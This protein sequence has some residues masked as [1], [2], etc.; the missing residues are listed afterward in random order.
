[1]ET[2]DPTNKDESEKKDMES[3]SNDPSNVEESPQFL[4]D[5]KLEESPYAETE[6]VKEEL[7]T[8]ELAEA[9]PVDT[10]V[11][12]QVETDQIDHTE[13][14]DEDK[15]ASKKMPGW[16][17]KS[18]IFLIIGLLLILAG[19]LISFYTVTNPLQKSLRIKH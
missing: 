16:L 11:D 12:A 18:L 6:R 4:V 3:G 10:T 1:M 17:R 5:A 8:E 14:Q 19:Y 9:S 7:E 13:S 2:E 15:P